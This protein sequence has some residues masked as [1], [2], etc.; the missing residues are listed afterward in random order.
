MP[1]MRDLWIFIVDFCQVLA[2]VLHASF[3][4]PFPFL[5]FSFSPILHSYTLAFI[6]DFFERFLFSFFSDSFF[7]L[8]FFPLIYSYRIHV[9]LHFGNKI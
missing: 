3:S 4:L 2:P 6:F 5:T 9:V 1:I 8:L 7:R